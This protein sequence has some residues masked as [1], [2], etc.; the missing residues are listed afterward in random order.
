MLLDRRV[1][2]RTLNQQQIPVPR[3]VICS[4]DGWEGRGIDIAIE[5]DD[6]VEVN[7]VRI[8]KP[9][10]EKPVDADDHNIHI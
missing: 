6:F 4:R 8:E 10:V 9:F 3:H 1:V 7:G 2:Y 5:G